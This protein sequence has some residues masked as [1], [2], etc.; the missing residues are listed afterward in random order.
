MLDYFSGR[1]RWHSWSRRLASRVPWSGRRLIT[2]LCQLIIIT[3]SAHFVLSDM[4]ER[5]KLSRTSSTSNTALVGSNI[6]IPDSG[7]Q[8]TKRRIVLAISRTCPF[9]KIELPFYRI[10]GSRRKEFDARLVAIMPES[11]QEAS[12]YLRSQMISV[13][14]LVCEPLATFGVTSTPTLVVLNRTGRVEKAWVG[15]LSDV[16]RNKVLFELVQLR[17]SDHR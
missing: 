13:D 7:Q 14:Q 17:R 10:L 1:H 11:C 12:E 6:S 9:C 2:I 3:C 16:E 4:I 8:S 5:R 15:A